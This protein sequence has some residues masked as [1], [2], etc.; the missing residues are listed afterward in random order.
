MSD[1]VV[2]QIEQD[3]REVEELFAE[4]EQT[5]ER[6]LADKICDELE[7]HTTAEEQAVYPVMRTELT[8]GDEEMEETEHEHADA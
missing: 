8:D 7:I 5:H 6:A 1:D 4:F 2:D 3:H